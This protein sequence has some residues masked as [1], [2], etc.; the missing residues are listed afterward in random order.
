MC[1]RRIVP[2]VLTVALLASLAACGKKPADAASATLAPAAAEASSKSDATAASSSLQDKDGKPVAIVPFDVA[3]LAVSKV[4][5]GELPFF[6]LPQGYEVQ[7][8]PHVRHWARFPVRMGDGLHW[9]SGATWSGLIVANSDSGKTFSALEVQRNL[10]NLITAAGGSK[11]FEGP[12]RREAYYGPTVE[13]EIGSGFIAAVNLSDATASVYAIRQ[14]D[15]TVWLQLATESNGSGAGLV[16]IEE[17]PFQ[18]SAMWANDFPHLAM[19]AGYSDRNHPAKR[20]FDRFPFWT[21][22]HFEQVEGRT[23]QADFG[24]EETTYSMDEVRRNLDAMLDSV[25]GTLLYAG[26]LSKAQAA[27]VPDAVK[28]AYSTGAGF[29]WDEYELRVYRANL[30]DGRE[31]WVHAR[32]DARSAGWVVAE[33]E[34]FKQTAALLPAAAL[35]QQLDASGKVALQVNFA[36]DKTDILPD[37]QPQIEQVLQLLKG[38]PDLKLAINGHTD[39]SGDAAHNQTLS[40]G[41]AKAVVAALTAK[42]IAATRLSAAGF[43]ASKPVAD[44]STDAG[45]AKN[46]RVELVKQ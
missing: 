23:W 25:H 10:E 41:R 38:N 17:K 12:L 26:R 5:L 22:D 46:R 30:P 34:G 37:S 44:N 8:K 3:T 21:G 13:D 7:N 42:G 29:G 33:R 39:N 2:L 45:K 40:E 43:G 28:S 6:G 27:S 36:T 14:A 19:P 18:P 4:N 11:V 35:K 32:L 15:R 24:K 9:V 16:V 1:Q 20:D 31:V